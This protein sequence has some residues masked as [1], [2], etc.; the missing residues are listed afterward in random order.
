MKLTK[1][2]LK[3]IIKEQIQENLAEAEEAVKPA[4]VAKEVMQCLLKA[5]PQED[6]LVVSLL[7]AACEA[8]KAGTVG[9][10]SLVLQLR[11]KLLAALDKAAGAGT[12]EP[13]PGVAP[14][15]DQPKV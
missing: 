12:P 4:E 1:E 15:P 7:R 2:K 9:R 5:D 13:E 11:E 10:N 14:T 8:A 3:N 6:Q